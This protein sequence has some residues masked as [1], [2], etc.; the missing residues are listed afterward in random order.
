VAQLDTDEKVVFAQ[1]III[2]QPDPDW[3]DGTFLKYLL[4]SPPVQE[5]IRAN[6]TGA[7]VRG[8]RASL[9]KR[10]GIAFP[11]SLEEQKRVVAR[12]DTLAVE[13]LRLRSIYGN[14]CV[15]L[16]ELKRSLLHQAFAGELGKQTA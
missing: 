7:T 12:L 15:A 6:G 5:R 10:I 9:L 2:M 1:R 13:T 8:I 16:Q 14:K 11:K 3:L 4:L